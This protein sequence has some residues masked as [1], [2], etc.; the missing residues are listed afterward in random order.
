[1]QLTIHSEAVELTIDV[2]DVGAGD[3]LKGFSEAF[4]SCYRD[5]RGF[6]WLYVDI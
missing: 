1:M 2:A 5:L 3:D 4:S 6:M